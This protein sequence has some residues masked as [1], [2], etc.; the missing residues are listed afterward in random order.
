MYFDVKICIVWDVSV[1]ILFDL[2][3]VVMEEQKFLLS[4][5]ITKSK[6]RGEKA[7]STQN[8]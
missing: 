5:G 4:L 7:T 3:I 8:L 1:G 6:H 2:N